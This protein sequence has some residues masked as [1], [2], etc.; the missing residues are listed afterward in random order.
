M[1]HQASGEALQCKRKC[2]FKYEVKLSNVRENITSST[3]WSSPMYEKILLQIQGEAFQMKEKII[4]QV[5]GEASNV[6]KNITSSM[7]WSSPMWE[8]ILLQVWSEILQFKTK[9]QLHPGNR[10]QQIWKYY[11]KYKV[12]LSNVRGNITSSTKWNSPI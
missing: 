4:P 10:F 7:R 6:R 12:K 1:L 8:E 5:Q 9:N 2:Y 3:R 11:F